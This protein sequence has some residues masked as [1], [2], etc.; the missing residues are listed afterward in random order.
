MAT[1]FNHFGIIADALPIVLGEIVSETADECRQN[2]QGFIRSNG[3]VKTGFMLDS[4]H[5]ED[6]PNEQTKFV[7]A[8]APYSVFQNYGTRFIPARA[9]WEPGIEP[10]RPGFE[11]RCSQI[12]AKLKAVSGA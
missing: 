2:I 9:F 7:I 5:V 3:Q 4:V 1:G 8:G 11:A 12:E 10:T 6:G